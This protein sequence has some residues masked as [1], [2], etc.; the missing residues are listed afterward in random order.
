ML[1]EEFLNRH[2]AQ[3]APEFRFPSV[4]FPVLFI[5]GVVILIPGGFLILALLMLDVLPELVMPKLLLIS[6]LVGAG[7]ALN[8]L[9]VASGWGLLQEKKRG[10]VRP[11]YESR[12]LLAIFVFFLATPFPLFFGAKFFYNYPFVRY[13]SYI[14][15]VKP[16]ADLER[17]IERFGLAEIK[18]HTPYDY[19]LERQ[20]IRYDFGGRDMPREFYEFRGSVFDNVLFGYLDLEVSGEALE[21]SQNL[22]S[23][24]S[25]WPIYE[26]IEGKGY[27]LIGLK[28][29]V[30]KLPLSIL[31]Q[32]GVEIPSINKKDGTTYYDVSDAFKRSA[33]AEYKGQ[34]IGGSDNKA[35]G[36]KFKYWA[37]Y[38]LLPS[39]AQSAELVEKGQHTEVEFG[40]TNLAKALR[41]L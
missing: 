1:L 20:V 22:M 26:I 14:L 33:E 11:N 28:S 8:A 30:G 36:L 9:S 35:S 16:S 32:D 4:V 25:V 37:T 40:F 6:G 34:C 39:F 15:E 38:I 7:L 27:C 41:Y 21:V 12:M 10:Y 24:S 31:I 19:S 18:W 29:D 13:P 17:E 23:D 2:R 5:V 3:W